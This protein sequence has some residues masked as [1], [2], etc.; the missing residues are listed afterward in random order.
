MEFESKNTCPCPP[1]LGVA[2]TSRSMKKRRRSS[3]TPWPTSLSPS[4]SPL[5]NILLF[6]VLLTWS[7]SW[8]CEH[9]R[10]QYCVDGFILP[11]PRFHSIR[12]SQISA[13][14]D[15]NGQESAVTGRSSSNSSGSPQRKGSRLQVRRRVKAVLEKARIRTGVR[16]GSVPSSSPTPPPPRSTQSIVAEAAALGGLGDGE[17]DIVFSSSTQIKSNGATVTNGVTNTTAAKNGNTNVLLFPDDK[18][19]AAVKND[20]SSTTSSSTTTTTSTTNIQKAN[21]YSDTTTTTAT[22]TTGAYTRKP[23]DFDVIRGDMPSAN[24]F[25]E[26]LPFKLPKLSA[27]QK[28]KLVNGECIQEQSRMGTEGS[29]Y[30]ILDVEAPPYVVW[31]CLLDFEA[32][33]EL[34]PV[35][36]S[37]QLYTTTKLNTGFTSEKSVL[38]GTGRET[39]HYGAPSITRASFILSNFRFNVVAILQYT[40]H[41]QGDYM[42]FTLDHLKGAKG[43]WYTEENPDGREV[44]RVDHFRHH[45]RHHFII[46]QQLYIYIYISTPNNIDFSFFLIH[47]IPYSVLTYRCTTRTNFSLSLLLLQCLFIYLFPFIIIIRALLE[48]I[49]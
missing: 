46:P 29:G 4:Q 44:S 47:P 25:V 3:Y 20:K 9:V 24:A 35:V 31:E 41:P 5:S 32:Y 43:T 15:R 6:V 28:K 2:D 23:K 30:V 13:D 38:P 11:Q 1:A 10:Q 14:L 40:P 49:Y 12:W 34:I 33:P 8:S 26:P 36:K 21:G 42:E 22:A 19:G 16:N 45:F 39:R 48:Y 7:G 18:N 17:L 27:D 37:M